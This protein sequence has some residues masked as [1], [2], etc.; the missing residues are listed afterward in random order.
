MYC[1]VAIQP[2]WLQ[3]CDKVYF[4]MG[5]VCVADVHCPTDSILAVSNCLHIQ[6]VSKNPLM[7][8]ALLETWNTRKYHEFVRAF[9]SGECTVTT[10]QWQYQGNV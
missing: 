9:Y 4:R 1:I 7:Q 5:I 6:A 8:Y 3:H 10:E 2:L